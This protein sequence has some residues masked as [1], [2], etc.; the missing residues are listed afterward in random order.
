MKTGEKLTTTLR[1]QNSAT[2]TRRNLKQNSTTQTNR[3]VARWYLKRLHYR[4]IPFNVRLHLCRPYDYWC[5]QNSYLNHKLTTEEHNNRTN[6]HQ[7]KWLSISKP[8]MPLDT[9]LLAEL[10]KQ[11]LKNSSTLSKVCKTLIFF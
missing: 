4:R 2:R 6:D 3:M 7:N 11:R 9:L 1:C 10:S 5:N 8:H